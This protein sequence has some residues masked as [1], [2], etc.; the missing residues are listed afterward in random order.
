MLSIAIAPFYIL[1]NIYIA[2]RGLQ[3]LRA[4]SDVFRKRPPSICYAVVYFLF[5]SSLL[6]AFFMPVSNA[7][8]MISRISNYWLGILLYI[9]LI[10]A[11]ADIGKIILHKLKILPD[12]IVKSRKAFIITGTAAV[13]TIT[14]VSAYG[15]IHVSNIKVTPYSV[16]VDKSGG[17]LDSLKIVLIADLH[18]GYS[19]GAEQV[20]KTVD[21]INSQNPDIVCIAGDIFDNSYDALDDPQKLISILGGIK[22]R[23]GSF[24][25]YG[26]HDVTE[27]ILGGF[28]FDHKSLKVQ[29]PR[30][31]TFLQ[32]ANIQVLD[33]ESAL[34][35]NSF[36]LVGRRDA[37]KPGVDH[38][39]TAAEVTY[40]L[41]RSKP[42]IVM[43][44][45]P[46]EFS[47]LANC[48]VDI[49][50][51]G[52]THDGQLFPGNLTIGIK[53]ENPC[54][55]LRKGNMHSIVT[56]GVGVWGPAMRVGTDSEI[57]VIDVSFKG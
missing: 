16:T 53:W 29:D 31:I 24:A 45:Q 22:S 6:T 5:A 18:L 10:M 36:Y 48:G 13:L 12:K 55:Y 35:D 3:W 49:D 23:Y 28:T 26:N 38:R 30:M 14:S 7:Q 32:S 19:V 41:D 39:K 33:D 34:I 9:L 44:H 1:L 56:S 37:Q 40:G 42:I 51:S 2:V 25:C 43:D 50:L 57:A 17:G 47:E 11:F 8:R 15:I 27:K 46:K 21:L 20:S 54:G 4:C 52:H